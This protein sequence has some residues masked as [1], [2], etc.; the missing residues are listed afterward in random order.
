MA[1]REDHKP[2]DCVGTH[3]FGVKKWAIGWYYSAIQHLV[4]K[5]YSSPKPA[6]EVFDLYAGPDYA[7]TPPP[8]FAENVLDDIHEKPLVFPMDLDIGRFENIIMHN[9]L[10]T[11][12]RDDRYDVHPDA[13]T[14]LFLV[15]SYFNHSCLPNAGRFCIGDVMIIRTIIDIPKGEEIAIAYGSV[16]H[17]DRRQEILMK[18]FKRCDCELC[19]ADRAD[20]SIRRS[21]RDKLIE[22]SENGKPTVSQ[23]RNL[24]EEGQE[25]LSSDV[26]HDQASIGICLQPALTIVKSSFRYLESPDKAMHRSFNGRA[27][28][29]RCSHPRQVNR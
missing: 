18:H 16:P 21:K 12:G 20:T 5:V 19:K 8:P 23:A 1:Y 4:A 6:S 13:A 15:P 22:E 3:D 26:W 17:Y 2:E 9:S 28:G 27:G 29:V 11:A 14:A 7:N 10:Q 24:V 25:D